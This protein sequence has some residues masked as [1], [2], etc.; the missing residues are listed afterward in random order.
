[1]NASFL[2]FLT[3]RLCVSNARS[4]LAFAIFHLHFLPQTLMALMRFHFYCSVIISYDENNCKENFLLIHCLMAYL[5]RVGAEND[6]VNQIISKSIKCLFFFHFRGS[7]AVYMSNDHIVIEYYH[8]PQCSSYLNS[9]F[10]PVYT[11][12]ILKHSS[13]C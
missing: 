1:M 13:F 11:Y 6:S 9:V 3:L 7:D 8:E 2:F 4:V 12:E 10:L 5:G